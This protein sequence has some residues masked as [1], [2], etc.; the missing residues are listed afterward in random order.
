[1]LSKRKFKDTYAMYTC[2][3]GKAGNRYGRWDVWKSSSKEMTDSAALIL[4][5]YML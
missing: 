4:L 2:S 1:M 5:K 3:Y